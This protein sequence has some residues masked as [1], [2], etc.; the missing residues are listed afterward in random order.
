[1]WDRLC[2]YLQY[3]SGNDKSAR[4]F[5]LVHF[6]RAFLGRNGRAERVNRTIIPT[7]GILTTAVSQRDETLNEFEYAINNCSWLTVL[8]IVQLMIF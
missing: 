1:M 6:P 5:E 7:V 2:V 8:L 4:Y 3:I